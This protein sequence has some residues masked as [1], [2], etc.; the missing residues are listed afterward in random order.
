MTGTQTED[1]EK[2]EMADRLAALLKQTL[3]ESKAGLLEDTPEYPGLILVM[4]A[5]AD[6]VL[7]MM[8]ATGNQYGII[9]TKMTKSPEIVGGFIDSPMT[10]KD[11]MRFVSEV[12]IV[13][14]K[15]IEEENVAGLESLAK[16]MTR[17]HKPECVLTLLPNTN[18]IRNI[19]RE[20][21]SYAL[22]LKK[23]SEERAMHDEQFARE[24][25]KAQHQGRLQAAFTGASVTSQ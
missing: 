23:Q 21:I 10:P 17:D 24:M 15:G 8:F 18:A 7:G 3:N 6:W 14:R 1:P 13:V 19:Q 22:E 9:V 25:D 12:E 20:C 4:N 11:F 16:L 5:R 2:T